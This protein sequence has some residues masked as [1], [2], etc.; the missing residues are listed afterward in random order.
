MFRA[1][2]GTDKSGRMSFKQG[3]CE[4]SLLSLAPVAGL[5]FFR[6]MRSLGISREPNLVVLSPRHNWSCDTSRLR[7]AGIL[8]N[9]RK[10]NMI[11][12]LDLF[13]GAM[14]RTLPPG[15]SFIGCFSDGNGKE[16]GKFSY[17]SVLSLVRKMLSLSCI[18]RDRR[19]SRCDVTG[20][21]EK[22]GFTA[23]SMMEIN[24]LTYFISRNAR[25]AV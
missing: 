8:I 10:L 25:Q 22:N 19:I 11:K 7:N 2:K 18:S 15:T 24:G 6:F 5:N 4:G 13:L 17:R 12:H 1:G 21:L 16:A 3:H 20:L 23:I 9:M 14:V